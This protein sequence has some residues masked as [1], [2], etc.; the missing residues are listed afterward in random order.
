M[1]Q[2]GP[3]DLEIWRNQTLFF[4]FFFCLLLGTC[5]GCQYY[6]LNLVASLV[7][8]P[9]I[10]SSHSSWL[11]THSHTQPT[12]SILYY[13]HIQSLNFRPSL[14]YF[15]KGSNKILYNSLLRYKKTHTKAKQ[16]EFALSPSPTLRRHRQLRPRHSIKFWHCALFALPAVDEPGE[17]RKDTWCGP[18]RHEFLLLQSLRLHG[19][20]SPLKRWNSAIKMSEGRM[21]MNTQKPT[22]T[23]DFAGYYIHLSRVSTTCLGTICAGTDSSRFFSFGHRSQRVPHYTTL[24][25]REG[26]YENW[27]YGRCLKLL[28]STRSNWTWYEICGGWNRRLDGNFLAS[29]FFFFFQQHIP[30]CSI[31]VIAY[32]TCTEYESVF[33]Y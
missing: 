1:T 15:L 12:W 6:L 32:W 23:L 24:Q 2:S 27:R 28:D 22:G 3:P 13:L 31:V 17:R 14:I 5:V 16:H 4:F 30:I 9:F 8:I 7:F 20:L 29:F 18:I 19:R 25:L 11:H 26:T 10:P 33:D 21:V